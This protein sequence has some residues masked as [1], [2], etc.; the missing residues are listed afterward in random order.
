VLWEEVVMNCSQTLPQS[1]FNTQSISLVEYLKSGNA[2]Q[3]LY[4]HQVEAVLKLREYF[5]QPSP[6]NAAVVT[7][8]IGCGGTGIAVLASY[9]LSASRVVVLAPSMA[10]SK[11]VY[12]SYGSFLID[13][14]VVAAKDKQVVLPSRSL[15]TQLSEMEDAM[16][17]SVIVTNAQNSDGMSSVKIT[18]IPLVGFDL[19][20]VYEAQYYTT[21]TW[22]IIT[23]HFS[24]SRLLFVTSAVKHKGKAVLGVKPCY[25]LERSVAVNQGILRDVEFDEMHGGNENFSYL[26]SKKFHVV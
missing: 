21:A 1:V 15:V 18:D 5:S 25:E 23:K 6:P 11:Q 7:V 24:N 22:K 8:P 16:A 12:A 3:Q 26:V 9:A 19:V 20:V 2:V 13:S 10:S 14:G 17:S 4:P